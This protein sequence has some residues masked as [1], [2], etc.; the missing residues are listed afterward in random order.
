MRL[1]FSTG[2]GPL[3][4]RILDPSFEVVAAGESDDF[5][6]LDPGQYLIELLLPSGRVVET[7]R[8]FHDEETHVVD[9]RDEVGD[10]HRGRARYSELFAE[11]ANEEWWNFSLEGWPHRFSTFDRGELRT[12]QNVHV[13]EAVESSSGQMA[14][15]VVD[16]GEAGVY[17]V[18]FESEAASPHVA[19]PAVAAHERC[20]VTAERRHDRV[21]VRTFPSGKMSAFARDYLRPG[22]G[23]EG[24]R[25]MARHDLQDLLTAPEKDPAGAAIYGYLSLREERGDDVAGWAGVFADQ[26][27]WM[28]DAR[29][30]AGAAAAGSGDD[31]AALRHLFA[32][33]KQGIPAFSEGIAVATALASSKLRDPHPSEDVTIRASWAMVLSDLHVVSPFVDYSVPETTFRFPWFWPPPRPWETTAI[34]D[35]P[36]VAPLQ[37][38]LKAANVQEHTRELFVE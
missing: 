38:R 26:V 7:A 6:W 10:V 12:T 13:V 22:R 28:P 34:G 9:F 33:C 2:A 19:L 23:E 18:Q 16:I 15:F 29:V 32:A 8:R 30:I 27:P 20:F 31:E 36:V 1:E 14:G 37:H 21:R 25:V 35:A 3:P 11:R 24:L 4:V 17:F 5:F